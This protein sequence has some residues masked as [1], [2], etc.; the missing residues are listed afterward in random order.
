MAALSGNEAACLGTIQDP[1]RNRLGVTSGEGEASGRGKGER[2][3][4]DDGVGEGR[5]R[6]GE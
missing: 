5:E 2:E 1:T 3:G 6:E 4:E